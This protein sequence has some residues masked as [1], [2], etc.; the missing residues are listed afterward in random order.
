MTEEGCY[1]LEH[2][3]ISVSVTGIA[4]GTR[5]LATGILA[6][7]VTR[8]PDGE[9]YVLGRKLITGVV[10][11][12]II[13]EH[14][15]HTLLVVGSVAE[16]K[17]IPSVGIR[18]LLLCGRGTIGIQNAIAKLYV[19]RQVKL[20]EIPC[21][22]NLAVA[23]PVTSGGDRTPADRIGQI[24]PVTFFILGKIDGRRSLESI[25]GGEIIVY[26]AVGLPV[27]IAICIYGP[28]FQTVAFCP[29]PFMFTPVFEMACGA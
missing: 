18:N 16:V 12:P 11:V 14:A 10:L 7:T 9:E 2:T 6:V 25:L 21:S 27:D 28:V 1:V 8:T 26:R 13:G 24:C 17:A 5:C 15:A 23:P 29:E 3:C 4:Q 20:L 19:W 22:R